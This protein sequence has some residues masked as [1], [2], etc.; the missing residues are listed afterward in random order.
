MSAVAAGDCAV[1]P[2]EFAAIAG[3]LVAD[4]HRRHHRVTIGAE[5]G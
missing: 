5:V 2:S 1:M 4:P 3:N